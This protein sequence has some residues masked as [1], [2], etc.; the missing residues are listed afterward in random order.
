MT[1]VNL[2]YSGSL[3]VS[4]PSQHPVLIV[5]QLKNLTKV[6]WEAIK[7]K[8]EPRVTE[9]VMKIHRPLL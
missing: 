5:G 7:A 2:K 9:E 8:L 1:N 3:N 4:D 6:R